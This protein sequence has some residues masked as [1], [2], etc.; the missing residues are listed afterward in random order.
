MAFPKSVS[1]IHQAVRNFQRYHIFT[2]GEIPEDIKKE[3]R[4][5]KPKGSQSTKGAAEYWVQ[6]CQEQLGLV[7][8]EEEE[9]RPRHIRFRD[10]WSPEASATAKA[11]GIP[12]ANEEGGPAAEHERPES[13]VRGMKRPRSQSADDH[14]VLSPNRAAAFDGIDIDSYVDDV[15]PTQPSSMHNYLP[16]FFE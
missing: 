8:V 13:P 15:H 7:D 9:D 10:D 5:F 1:L 12:D 11:G 3:L 4:D 16:S 14:D 2:C 6:S